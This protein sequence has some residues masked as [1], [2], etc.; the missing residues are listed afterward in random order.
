MLIKTHKITK[1]YGGNRILEDISAQVNPGEKIGLVGKNGIGK[2][3]LIK[4]MIEELSP[5]EGYIETQ[6]NINIGYLPQ[7][8]EFSSDDTLY[9]KLKQVF[10][11]IHALEKELIHL[12][13]KMAEETNS[14]KLDSIM[15]KYSKIRDEFENKGGYQIDRNIRSILKG[16][17]FGD[18]EF[19]KPLNNFSG[20]EKT[21]ALLAKKLLQRPDILILD[22]PTNYLD[23][24]G[25][26]W[27]EDYLTNYQE[28][29]IIITHDRYFLE[30][31]VNVIWELSE[32]GLTVY[33][34]NYS[35]YIEQKRLL[36]E[37]QEKEY[38]KQQKYFKKTEDFIRKNIEGQ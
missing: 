4:L 21:R 19:S 8:P 15:N 16:L 34:G 10:E 6:N 22:E 32:E 1:D 3:T 33:K 28:N 7:Q 30:N 13:N 2:T 12:E 20:G 31:T 25:L 17:G 24:D 29:F 26:S 11:N 37:R 38:E 35:S 14:E 27:L 23:L 5:D 18:E 36:E 9:A